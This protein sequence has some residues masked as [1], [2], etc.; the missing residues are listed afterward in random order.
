MTCIMC[1]CAGCSSVRDMQCLAPWLD[2]LIDPATLKSDIVALGNILT[3]D[4]APALSA[5]AS[6]VHDLAVRSPD[7]M[8][9]DHA[10]VPSESR[11]DCDLHDRPCSVKLGVMLTCHHAMCPLR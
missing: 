8:Q 6:D 4:L 7:A 5:V 1:P 11:S 2:T 10:F 9:T 3:D